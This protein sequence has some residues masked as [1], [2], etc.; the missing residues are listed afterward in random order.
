VLI[1]VYPDDSVR[2][3]G[4]LQSGPPL[5]SGIMRAVIATTDAVKAADAYGRGL[6]LP[7]TEAVDDPERGVTSVT[8]T[9]PKGG[10]I[11]LVSVTDAGR[12]FGGAVAATLAERGEGLFAIVLQADDPDAAIDTLRR[13]GVAVDGREA[14]VSGA[15][16][17]I[18]ARPG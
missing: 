5:L 12:P 10:V 3:P 17:L 11:E 4:G 13:R 16:I 8:V 7:A 2:N 9:P 14:R 18:E 15:R 6:D 1:R